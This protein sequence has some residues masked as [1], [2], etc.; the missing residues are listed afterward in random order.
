MVNCVTRW[1]GNF[2]FG[3]DNGLD[4]MNEDLT[5]AAV[6]NLTDRFTGVRIRNLYVDNRNHLWISTSGSGLFEVD[7]WGNVT[8]YTTANGLPGN[9]LR[10]VIELEDGTIVSAGDFGIA[11]IENGKVTDV[12]GYTDGLNNPKVLCLL[13]QADGT[14]LAGTDGGGVSVIRER[15]V[16]QTLTRQD[17]LGSEVILRMISDSDGKG[18]FFVTSNIRTIRESGFWIFRIIIITIL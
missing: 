17:G 18:T 6:N 9:K 12:I 14:V 4:M 7:K 10:M 15:K 5:K 8:E 3:T 1:N 16:V 2:C 11:Y 13:E